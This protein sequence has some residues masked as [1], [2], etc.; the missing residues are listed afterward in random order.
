METLKLNL[1]TPA[2]YVS[3]RAQVFPS[4]ESFRWFERANRAELVDCGAVLKPTGRKLIDPTACDAAV[5]RI[6]KRLAAPRG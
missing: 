2:E 5:M 1:I 6:G 3:A 4:E